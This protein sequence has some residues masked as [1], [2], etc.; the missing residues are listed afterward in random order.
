MRIAFL[1]STI[2]F[3]ILSFAE[4]T[5]HSMR[6]ISPLYV[7]IY[8]FDEAQMKYIRESKIKVV[9]VL[10]DTTTKKYYYNT[11][12]TL[13]QITEET[14]KGRKMSSET[15]KYNPNNQLI[16][17]QNVIYKL[18]TINTP[19]FFKRKIKYYLEEFKNVNDSFVYNKQ[20]KIFY[21]S[22]R[23]NVNFDY[24]NWWYPRFETY[25]YKMTIK[26]ENRNN[27]SLIY[28]CNI[29][30][31]DEKYINC[32][33]LFFIVKGQFIGFEN[34]LGQAKITVNCDTT[35]F[36]LDK[37]KSRGSSFFTIGSCSIYDSLSS[38]ETLYA[39]SP[40]ILMP[41]ARLVQK[42]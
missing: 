38:T 15:F 29:D 19:A 13:D 1:F 30:S 26:F 42:S 2:L 7:D 5:P 22:R 10:S 24:V 16:L 33:S 27:D 6:P 21:A 35:F 3:T 36:K 39:L 20:G 32:P 18:R 40:Y 34:H 23:G 8:G 9:S 28:S 37:F 11:N 41:S 25:P 17:H 12:F 4:A 14:K 31:T